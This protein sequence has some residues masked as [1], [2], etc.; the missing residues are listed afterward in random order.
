MIITTYKELLGTCIKSEK[1]AYIYI[2]YVP[3]LLVKI[4]QTSCFATFGSSACQEK[5][6]FPDMYNSSI[7]PR[8]CP[9][10]SL[11]LINT[12]INVKGNKK[13]KN[14]LKIKLL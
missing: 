2:Q 8:K 12:Q 3:D 11:N 10:T 14:E 4:L 6:V 9:R 7:L 13:V 5:N 1:A